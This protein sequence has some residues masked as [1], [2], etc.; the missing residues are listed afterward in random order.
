MRVVDSC[1]PDYQPRMIVQYEPLE[2]QFDVEAESFLEMKDLQ[3]VGSCESEDGLLA[4]YHSCREGS[5]ELIYPDVVNTKSFFV[6][7]NGDNIGDS[8]NQYVKFQYQISTKNG[9]VFQ[10]RLSRSNINQGFLPSATLATMETGFSAGDD[11]DDTELESCST[12]PYST[13]FSRSSCR[14]RTRVMSAP[15]VK[16]VT[17]TFATNSQHP[18][19]S[20]SR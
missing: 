6:V 10:N 13:L 14:F 5:E 15:A 4:D 18:S 20:V 12:R 7:H 8:A 16:S 19:T 2:S 9:N 11:D 1:E 3:S 17:I